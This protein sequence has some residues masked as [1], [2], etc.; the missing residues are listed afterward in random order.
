M[1]ILVADDDADIRDLTA[2]LL[3]GRGWDVTTVSS[4]EQAAAALAEARYD[5]AVLDQSMPPGSGMEVAAQRR[6]AG[7]SIPI[8]LWTGWSGTLDKEEIAR[9]D[10][11][12][13]EKSDVRQL[14][15]LVQQLT[16]SE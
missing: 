2:C 9:L 11:H 15:E 3:G 5:L 16:G 4:G 8:V 7:D 13:L 1:K 12:L 14:S 10:V 6:L